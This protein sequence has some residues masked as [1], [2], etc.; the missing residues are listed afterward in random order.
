[1]MAKNIA[2][3]I[4]NT[5]LENLAKEVDREKQRKMLHVIV[6]FETGTF[7]HIIMP[8]PLNILPN[9]REPKSIIRPFSPVLN[10]SH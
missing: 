2:F 5:I 4:A 3:F 1:M 6:F 9:G 10:T 7:Y 8:Y